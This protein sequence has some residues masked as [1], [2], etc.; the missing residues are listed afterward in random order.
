[1]GATYRGGDRVRGDDG[2]GEEGL[3]GTSGSQQWRSYGGNSGEV[4]QRA[5]QE[6]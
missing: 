2:V 5:A 4:M 6:G 1:M 3:S